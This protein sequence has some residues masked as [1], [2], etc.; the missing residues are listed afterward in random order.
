MMVN[1]LAKPIGI[2]AGTYRALVCIFM[3]GGN[4][5]N[6]MVI[7]YDG[8]ADYNAVRGDQG[9]G[10]GIS[11]PQDRLLQITPTTAGAVFGLHPSMPEIQSLFTQKKAA[12][13]TNVGSLIQPITPDDYRMGKFRPYQL[14]SHSDQQTEWQTSY[15][16]SPYPTG[17]A[18]RTADYFGIDPSGFPTIASISG[19]TIFSAGA[20]TRPLVLPDAN[21]QLKDTLQLFRSGDTDPS[22]SLSQLLGFDG[23]VGA[24]TLVR[25]VAKVTSLALKN[26]VILQSN[27]NV[28]S[29]FPNTGVGRQ[30]KQVARLIKLAQDPAVNI[31]R[32]IFFCSIGGFDT[33]NNQGNVMGNQANLLAQVS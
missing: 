7:P 25:D 14:F 8:Y 18:G 6:N 23:G 28:T 16:N 20:S 11:I 9:V 15:A 12:I 24:P 10:V 21:T 32:Q 31:N 2:E 27:P 5:S 26:S 33:H 4:D 17:W 3:F 29:P 19:V 1:A 30:L 13:V 22:S